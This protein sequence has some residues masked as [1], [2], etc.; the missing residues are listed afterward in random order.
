MQA[1]I[2]EYLK[3]SAFH[4]S[5]HLFIVSRFT[6]QSRLLVK[7]KALYMQRLLISDTQGEAKEYHYWPN[8]KHSGPNL[9]RL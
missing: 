3:E 1:L 7:I 8:Q 6:S 9:F 4:S 2:I 5:V